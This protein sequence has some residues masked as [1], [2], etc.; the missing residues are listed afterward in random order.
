MITEI[1][2]YV[3]IVLLFV[4]TFLQRRTIGKYASVNKSLKESNESALEIAERYQERH[5]EIK[6]DYRKQT[7]VLEMAQDRVENLIDERRDMHTAHNLEV[8]S[9]K[10]ENILLRKVINPDGTKTTAKPRKA[11]PSSV[12]TPKATKATKKVPTAIDPNSIIAPSAFVMVN[13]NPAND[14]DEKTKR[15]MIDLVK[16]QYPYSI[17]NFV[18]DYQHEIVEHESETKP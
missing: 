8:D 1:L 13:A 3:T 12:V 6:K 11:V 14:V 2:Q 17:Q 15:K 7:R 5:K 9:L 18:D 10:A 4:V 16:N